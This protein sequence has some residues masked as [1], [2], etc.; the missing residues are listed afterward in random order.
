MNYKLSY[1]ITLLWI[2][3]ISYAQVGIGN[4]NP[5]GL[6][7]LNNNHNGD[8]TA[9]LDVLEKV[10]V[11]VEVDLVLSVQDYLILLYDSIA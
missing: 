3:G 5:R 11:E 2:S 10:E 8:A 6:L 1:C 4:N 9:G 7:D